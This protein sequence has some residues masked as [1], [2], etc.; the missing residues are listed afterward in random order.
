[1]TSDMN[2]GAASAFPT[3]ASGHGQTS[4]RPAATIALLPLDP[5]LRT[6]TD[7]PSILTR[8][9]TSG[10]V[11]VQQIGSMERVHLCRRRSGK[12]V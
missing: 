12:I 1:M 5:E 4:Y 2:F 6:N 9:A 7:R 8:S 3:P 11:Q 10:C